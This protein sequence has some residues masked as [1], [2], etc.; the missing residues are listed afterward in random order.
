[1]CA[2]G[3]VEEE[4]KKLDFG[5]NRFS[6]IA[7][8]NGLMKTYP[9]LKL[10]CSDYDPRFRP[11]YVTAT[12]GKKNLILMID[13]SSSMAGQRIKLAAEAAKSVVQ[14]LGVTDQFAVVTFS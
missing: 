10:D 6:Y 2:T 3:E 14:S 9:G 13:T 1:M 7:N 4:L 5:L 12:S 8:Y 11:W